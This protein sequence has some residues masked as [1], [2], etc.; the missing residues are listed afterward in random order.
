MTPRSKVIPAPSFPSHTREGVSEH[1]CSPE[2]GTLWDPQAHQVPSDGPASL[3][4][5]HPFAVPPPRPSCPARPA[6]ALLVD[7]V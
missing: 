4:P 2:R 1:T 3:L 7:R 5:A 6:T